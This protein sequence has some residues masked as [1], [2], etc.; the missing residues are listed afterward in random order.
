MSHVYFKINQ[1]LGLPGVNGTFSGP[2]DH[3]VTGVSTDTRTLKPG[4]L[5]FAIQGERFD[6]H[7]FVQ[8]AYELD[9]CAAVVAS[10]WQPSGITGS[11]YHTSTVFPAPDHAPCSSANARFRRSTEA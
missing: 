11:V 5:F 9:A 7:H 2:A 4:D 6:G 8:T 3:A 10:H 1:V